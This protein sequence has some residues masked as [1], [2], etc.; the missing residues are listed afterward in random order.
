MPIEEFSHHMER[1]SRLWHV[2]VI[3]EAME[4]PFPYM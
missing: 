1:I 4:Q 3:E 2:G